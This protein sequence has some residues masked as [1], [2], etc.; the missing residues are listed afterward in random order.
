MLGS[1]VAVESAADRFGYGTLP[2][3][4]DGD[5]TVSASESLERP[6]PQAEDLVDLEALLQ[7]VIQDTKFLCQLGE[8][9]QVLKYIY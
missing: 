9:L 3:L 7:V 8:F 4:G 2:P 6:I 5:S 1:C